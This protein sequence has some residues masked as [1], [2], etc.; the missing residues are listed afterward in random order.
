MR[1]CSLQR[2][3]TVYDVS[4][5]T[6]PDTCSMYCC[7]A[8]WKLNGV[9]TLWC[10]CVLQTV[11]LMACSHCG[12]KHRRYPVAEVTLSAA[13]YCARCDTRHA[14]KE[15]RILTQSCRIADASICLRVSKG[16]APRLLKK[17]LEW[18]TPS[19]LYYPLLFSFPPDP[20]PSVYPFLT[21]FSPTFSY[22][23]AIFHTL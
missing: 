16:P 9:F 2:H 6:Q 13:R 4:V 7:F 5:W 18:H 17:F 12:G 8:D 15:A 23:S 14:V 22:H 1:Y 10:A 3:F 19:P 20:F 11:N 21:P